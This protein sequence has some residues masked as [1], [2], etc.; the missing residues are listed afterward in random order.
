MIIELEFQSDRN[1]DSEALAMSFR[2]FGR[3]KTVAENGLR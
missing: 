1:S 3:R 2:Q